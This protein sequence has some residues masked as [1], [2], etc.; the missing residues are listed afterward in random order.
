MAA[1]PAAPRRAAR[2]P[3]VLFAGRHVAYKGVDVLLRALA[4]TQARAVIAGDGPMRAA[5]EALA[6]ELGARRAGDVSPATWPTPSC[7]R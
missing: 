1:T 4:G 5:W 7:A 3:F 2:E 6:R